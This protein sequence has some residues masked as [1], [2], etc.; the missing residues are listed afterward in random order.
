M[1]EFSKF[2]LRRQFMLMSF[3][4]LLIGMLVIGSFLNNRITANVLNETAAVTAL[5]VNSIISPQLQNL[6]TEENIE[7]SHLLELDRLLMD[8]SLKDQIVSFK[9]W[10]TDGRIIYSPYADLIGNK[11]QIDH[12]LETALLGQVISELSSLDKPE[13]EYESQKWDYLIETYAP[14]RADSDGKVIAV[15]EFYQLP[16]RLDAQLKNAQIQSW[17][18][19]GISTFFMYLLLTGIVRKASN[20]IQ[21]QQEELNQK[22]IQL[23]ELLSQNT[24]LNNRVRKAAE[25][26]TELN[27]QF[28][29][30]ISADFHD[31]PIQDL[32]LS[33]LRIE[34]VSELCQECPTQNTEGQ[35]ISQDLKLTQS[36]LESSLKEFRSIISGLR[37]P[38]LERLTLKNVV[39][40]AIL[41][42]RRKTKRN[43]SLTI[44]NLPKQVPLPVKIAIYRVLQEALLNGFHHA[45]TDNQSVRLLYNNDEIQL[46]VIDD[47][48]GFDPIAI[49]KENHL[50]ISGMRERIEIL[51]GSFTIISAPEEGTCIK[52]VIP[53]EYSY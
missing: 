7:A 9:V 4:I 20:T 29:R 31:G 1:I 46:E 16:D 14:I 18:V 22:I 25:R 39:D 40:R 38:E 12:D 19:V 24:K 26:T 50:G 41:N 13:H 45:S 51:G 34:E 33:L 17:L 5:F 23:T 44:D 30:R 53:L 8:S 42:Y 10:S 32:A 47:G 21:D 28:L 3:L 11:Y 37:L 52:A 43:V 36:T 15:A 48:V 49:N 35:L 27:E 6:I 2:S